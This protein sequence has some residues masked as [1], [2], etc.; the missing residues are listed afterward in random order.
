MERMSF[1]HRLFAGIATI[2]SILLLISAL[3][4]NTSSNTKTQMTV[5]TETHLPQLVK[6]QLMFNEINTI[7]RALRNMQVI[8]FSTPEDA[9]LAEQEWQRIAQA[10]V[11][12]EQTM[13]QLET[14][15][16][17]HSDQA[18]LQRLKII[19]ERRDIFAKAQDEFRVL[20][21][22]GDLAASRLLLMG[23]LRTKYNAYRDEILAL[24]EQEQTAAMRNAGQ[25]VEL[26]SSRQQLIL[27]VSLVGIV[28]ASLIALLLM[29]RV[30]LQLGGELEA[31][32]RSIDRIAQ[33]DLTEE[34]RLVQ[35]DT[36]SVMARLQKC[37]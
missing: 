16:A 22:Q 26:S 11:E 13:Q 23:E 1:S 28:V 30:R 6:G 33:G 25:L 36:S 37:S 7:A 24:T 4:Y 8:G 2:V 35:Q 19:H 15:A 10:R 27:F 29:R 34:L 31:L 5:L 21:Q 18:L 3:A 9:A 17:S 32:Q 14:R 20:F 12:I